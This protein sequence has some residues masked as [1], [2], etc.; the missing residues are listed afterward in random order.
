MYGCGDGRLDSGEFGRTCDMRDMIAD[1][2]RSR[3]YLPDMS[4][5]GGGCWAEG[6][7]IRGGD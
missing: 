2:V 5:A 7:A 3:G 6:V 4:L 1:R